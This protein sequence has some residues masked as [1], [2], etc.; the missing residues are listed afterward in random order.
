MRGEDRLGDG[1]AVFGAGAVLQDAH[2]RGAQDDA[3]ALPRAD[4]RHGGARPR[5]TGLRP[6]GRLSIGTRPVATRPINKRSI[7][8]RP[9]GTRSIDTL[10][11]DTRPIG[12]RSI[13]TRA[14]GRRPIGTR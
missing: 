5:R 7:A 8:T 11:V 12:T 1:Q 2:A 3:L 4:H 10:P 13:A 6:V 14:I 9:I